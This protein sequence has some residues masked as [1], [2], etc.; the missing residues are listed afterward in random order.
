MDIYFVTLIIL[1]GL[2]YEATTKEHSR[3]VVRNNGHSCENR[4][5]LCHHKQ[6]T[7]LSNDHFGALRE[8]NYNTLNLTRTPTGLMQVVPDKGILQIQIQN[9]N[10][11]YFTDGMKV[12]HI[13][14]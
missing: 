6:F 8:F 10:M 13:F 2:S 4:R 3:I 11:A 12:K 14:F 9:S 5:C 7:T 1:N